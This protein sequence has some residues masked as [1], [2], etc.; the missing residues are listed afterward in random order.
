MSHQ[1]IESFSKK[2]ANSVN[3]KQTKENEIKNVQSSASIIKNKQIL[4]Q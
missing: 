4:T 1:A 3:I 2:K